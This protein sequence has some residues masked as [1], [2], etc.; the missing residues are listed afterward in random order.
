VPVIL[1]VGKSEAEE[2]KETIRRLG[3]DKQTVQPLEEALKM[4]S[5]EAMAPDLRP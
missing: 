1:E 3:S 2:R 4:L 5:E